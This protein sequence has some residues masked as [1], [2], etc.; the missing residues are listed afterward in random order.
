MG[1]HQP[2][3]TIRSRRPADR[4]SVSSADSTVGARVSTHQSRRAQVNSQAGFV[5]Y[6]SSPGNA[7]RTATHDISRGSYHVKHLGSFAQTLEDA[8][9]DVTF[10]RTMIPNQQSSARRT[11]FHDISEP[12]VFS[13]NVETLLQQYYQQEPLPN[14]QQNNFIASNL[15]IEVWHVCAWFHHQRERD[16]VSQQFQKL[17]M[18]DL[19]PTATQGARMILPYLLNKIIEI[20]PPGRTLLIDLRPPANY[21]KSH[22]RGAI[23][24]RAPLR[25][26]QDASFDM[27]ER[28][29]SDRESRQKFGE[30][31]S[32][33]CMVF[34]ARAVDS[35]WECPVAGVLYEKFKSWGWPGR[36][37][38]LKGHYREFSVSYSKPIHRQVKDD[39]RGQSTYRS[40]HLGQR[41]NVDVVEG[42]DDE[43]RVSPSLSPNPSASPGRART[44]S[45]HEQDLEAEFRRRVPDL[46]C[47]ALDAQGNSG[48]T[49]AEPSLAPHSASTE[50]AME[51]S[52]CASSG[53]GDEDKDRGGDRDGT[54]A[55]FGPDTKAPLVE[56][57][58]RGLSYVRQGRPANATVVEASNATSLDDD[59]K[60]TNNAPRAGLSKLAAEDLHAYLN[61]A[62]IV[63]TPS[64]DSYIKI[65]K[66]DGQQ[67]GDHAPASPGLGHHH[68]QNYHAGLGEEGGDERRRHCQWPVGR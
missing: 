19:A 64:D 63:S 7:P 17:K 30:W 24:L 44:M 61:S 43:G 2:Y 31:Q 8:S 5:Q 11:I 10:S 23:N 56:Y 35:P 66:G 27:I 21:E 4:D 6:G 26:V 59:T 49:A 34:Y 28:A 37:F 50:T 16:I 3:V 12:P 29:F 67:A 47:K 55:V 57:L 18:G 62:V 39:G 22:I 68:G 65:A 48:G 32:T 25:F 36:C 58:D 1:D 41:P 51:A 33:M 45:Q 14:D 15:G 52:E 42:T 53:G 20:L 54:T 9:P 40:P 46:Y 13:Q 60:P 38:I